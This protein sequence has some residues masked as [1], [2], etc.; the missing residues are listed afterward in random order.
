MHFNPSTVYLAGPITGLAYG[1]TTNWRLVA[2][3]YLGEVSLGKVAGVSPMRQKEYLS[4]E[5]EIKDSY[6]T[7]LSNPTGILTRDRWDA[8]HCT[9][10]LINVLQAKKVSI[11]TVM[12]AAWADSERIPIVLIMEDA[13]NP[14]DHAM[15][16]GVAGFVTPSLQ[17]GLDVALSI[18]CNTQGSD[19]HFEKY[20]NEVA[21]LNKRLH[22]S[23]YPVAL[24]P[25]STMQNVDEPLM[26]SDF[27]RFV[28]GL[29]E[30]ESRSK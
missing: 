30:I 13:G 3:N 28:S 11:G 25:E 6:E 22:T 15:L 21:G 24:A 16:R 4:K 18:L 7:I 12:E 29:R 9:L 27:N 19:W 1:T 20:V 8:T 2:Q 23:A 10:I 17:Q 26:R 5:Q 14:H